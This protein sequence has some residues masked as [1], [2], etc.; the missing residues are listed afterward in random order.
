MDLGH[1]RA[2]TGNGVPSDVDSPAPA[3]EHLGVSGPESSSCSLLYACS[4]GYTARLI[5]S[6]A[7]VIVFFG[8][9]NKNTIIGH[10]I[11]NKQE[12]LTVLEAGMSK[13]PCLVREPDLGS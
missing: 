2:L 8:C 10:L 9:Y 12:F 5:S 11:N 7:S 3:S 4:R 6:L 13:I 1:L